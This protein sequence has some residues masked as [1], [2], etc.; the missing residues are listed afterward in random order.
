MRAWGFVQSCVLVAAMA[1]TA[2]ADD[3]KP[4]TVG[5]TA[6]QKAEAQRQLEAGNELFLA[7]K[8]AEAIEQYRAA[9]KTWDHPAIRFNI[10]RCLIQLEKPLEAAEQL[11]L[12]LKYGDA[13]FEEGIYNEALG[14]QKLLAN[15]SA[16]L[17]VSC[18]Q[19]GVTM[20]LDGQSLAACPTRETRRVLP[21]QHQVVG[22]KAGMLPRTIEIVVLGGKREQVGVELVPLSKGTRI[23][24]RWA[25]WKPWTVF[26]G[27]FALAGIGGLLHLK[28]TSDQDEYRDLVAQ[29]CPNGCPAGE[30]SSSLESSARIENGIA[31]GAVILGGAAIVTGSV[32]IYMNRGRT[33][34]GAKEYQTPRGA[35]LDVVPTRSGGAVTLSGW[36]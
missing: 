33:V 11:T 22:T 23:E 31:L 10:V 18:T 6:D 13:P 4:W 34:Y 3:S 9:V 8:Y 17:E 20:T 29:Q 27:G 25:Q 1:V 26:A 14:Y 12:A 16:E 21:G 2:R 5:V 30:V 36:F 35:R 19:P 32:M 28:A 24:H 7:R 15:Q